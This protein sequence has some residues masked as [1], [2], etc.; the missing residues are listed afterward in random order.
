MEKPAVL[1]FLKKHPAVMRNMNP[2]G[3]KFLVRNLKNSK[4]TLEE[5]A[6]DVYSNSAGRTITFSNLLPE[7]V[8]LDLDNLIGDAGLG[9]AE[10]TLPRESR[11]QKSCRVAFA[12]LA[13]PEAA[14]E[15]VRELNGTKIRGVPVVVQLVDGNLVDSWSVSHAKMDESG[16]IDVDAMEDDTNHRRISWKKDDELWDVSLFDRDESVQNFKER[17]LCSAADIVGAMAP[18]SEEA[19]ARFNAAATRE[20]AEEREMMQDALSSQRAG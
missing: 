1:Q 18:M 2:E 4:E 3:V 7:V 5:A 9:P 20:R 10:V 6:G 14:V 16:P 13:S 15:A 12:V 19:A 11:K 8:E 17:L